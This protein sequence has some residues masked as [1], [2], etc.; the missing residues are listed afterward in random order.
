MVHFRGYGGRPGPE[1]APLC[2]NCDRPLERWN[3]NLPPLELVYVPKRR[4]V[5][6]VCRECW[7]EAGAVDIRPVWARGAS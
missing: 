6:R 3:G 4:S 2:A 1:S 5:A 7:V